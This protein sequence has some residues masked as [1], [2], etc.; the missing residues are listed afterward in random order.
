MSSKAASSQG[1]FH[2]KL[3]NRDEWLGYRGSTKG[4]SLEVQPAHVPGPAPP[5]IGNV[6]VKSCP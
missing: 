6:E 3:K 5:R 4:V 1:F 2:C